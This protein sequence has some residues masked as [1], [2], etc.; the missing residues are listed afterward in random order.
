MFTEMVLDDEIII[1]KELHTFRL[2]AWEIFMGLEV[3]E[4]FMVYHN[5][6]L[7]EVF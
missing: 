2:D 6:Y 5:I 7:L 4:V 3:C 1:Y